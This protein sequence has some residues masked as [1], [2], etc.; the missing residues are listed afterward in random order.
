MTAGEA[1]RAE[2]EVRGLSQSEFGKIFRLSRQ[3]VCTVERGKNL[4][5]NAERMI[6]TLGIK[7]EP[8]AK[9][10]PTSRR[11]P[12]SSTRPDGAVRIDGVDLTVAEAVAAYSENA[13]DARRIR[14][15]LSTRAECSSAWLLR[16]ISKTSNRENAPIKTAAQAEAQR[17]LLSVDGSSLSPIHAAHYIARMSSIRKIALF[18]SCRR[19]SILP[20]AMADK[21]P[22][23]IG[24]FY[25]TTPAVILRELQA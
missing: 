14:D 5:V 20:A 4:S 11:F 10:P 1:I 15:R 21:S 7:F 19:I 18:K 12:I 8:K 13:I 22:H 2:R 23:V 25:R 17:E 24:V 9:A 3:A 16:P 6:K